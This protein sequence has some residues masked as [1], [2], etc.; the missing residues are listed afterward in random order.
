MNRHVEALAEEF[1]RRGDDVRVLAP[2]DPPGRVSRVL[3][4]AATEPRQLP[5][6]LTPLGRTIGFGANGVRL[7]PGPVPGRAGVRAPPR[8]PGRRLR[9]APRPR[10]PGPA[11]RLE[12][13]ARLAR[14]RWSAPST[15]TRPS[16]C[17]TTSPTSPAPGAS[18]TAF[19][20][21]SPS[22][23]R[24]PGPARRWY[25]GD[26]TIV[27]NGVD[28]DAAPSA[29]GRPAADL[30]IFSVGRPEERKGLPSCWGP[31]RPG[32]PGPPSADRDRRRPRRRPPLPFRPGPAE[33]DRLPRPGLERRALDRA[34][35]RADVLC[36]P[37]LSG[38]SFGM[39][40]T[41]AFAAGTPVIASGIAGYSDVVTDGLDGLLVPPGDPQ[42]LAEE[43]QRAHHEPDRL[44]DDGRGGARSAQRFAWPRVA[45]QVPEVYERAIAVPSRSSR[46][47][48]SPRAGMLPSDGVLTEP[49]RSFLRSTRP[50]AP[51]TAA[52][53]CAAGRP[54]HRRHPRSRP[55]RS[56]GAEDR[57]RPRRRT[58]RPLRSS[59][60][61]WIACALMALSLFFRAAS[62]Y[63]IAR[64]A[65]P[66]R[67][68]SRR[69]VTSATMIGV[70]MSATLPARL[71]EPA[72]RDRAR[73]PHRPHAGNLP[74]PPRNPGL[75]DH[76]EP[77]RAGP[78]RR[79]HRL[80][81]PALPLRHPEALRL[82]PRSA[83]AC[84][85]RPVRA[86]R[87]AA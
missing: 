36:A 82:Q 29:P 56:G 73:P 9:R 65:L 58:H 62:W 16:R 51:A 41:Q 11:G 84:W 23:R 43:L 13:D 55:H 48:A 5:D 39:V 52:A 63:W 12:R 47:S 37:S 74:G 17:R 66:N 22:P 46:P 61:C 45:D 64:A 33:V 86:A 40:L 80:D 3:H 31:R 83:A 20:P 25:G 6:Y 78:A 24:L 49:P 87:D 68:V 69:D 76:A 85:C 70:L 57:P 27:P 60:G 79:D 32:R 18:A 81:H 38:E 21:G 19:P 77:L 35:T 42:R 1:L 8:D 53:A 75:A 30:R 44:R 67:P 4:R 15:P 50:R 2:F 7:Q 34:A 71:G 59:P 26:Y 72:Q 54:R 10:A 14:R 28:V